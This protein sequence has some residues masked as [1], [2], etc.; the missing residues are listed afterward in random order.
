MS[1]TPK[2][3]SGSAL[4]EKLMT[5]PDLLKDHP[6]ISSNTPVFGTLLANSHLVCRLLLLEVPSN[7]W[8][9]AP[10]PVTSRPWPELWVLLPRARFTI[11]AYMVSFT[12]S[13]M[14]RGPF[15]LAMVLGSANGEGGGRGYGEG[16]AMTNIITQP[17]HASGRL[18][19]KTGVATH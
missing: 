11:L 18:A 5:S 13:N 1:L 10:E 16:V 7:T 12:R 19:A 9:T 15:I 8:T 2:L 3:A 4:G 14:T 6:G 17:S